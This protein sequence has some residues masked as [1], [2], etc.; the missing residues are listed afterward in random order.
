MRAL[1]GK[2]YWPFMKQG[3]CAKRLKNINGLD[4]GHKQISQGP[5]H[6]TL[7]SLTAG[8]GL[9]QKTMRVSLVDIPQPQSRLKRADR[10][11]WIYLYC[12]T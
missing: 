11:V 3:S 1:G 8:E 4:V 9:M 2:S 7:R 5:R 6:V 12:N 10:F